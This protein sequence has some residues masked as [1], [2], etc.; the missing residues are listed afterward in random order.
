MVKK[1]KELE[2]QIKELQNE[3]Q[4]LK[5]KIK[6]CCMCQVRE[7][8]DREDACHKGQIYYGGNPDNSG[9]PRS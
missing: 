4:R 2:T 8:L 9:S 7:R 1:I 6:N 3:V 5:L